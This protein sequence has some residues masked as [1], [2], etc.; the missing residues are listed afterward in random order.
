MKNS[1][2]LPKPYIEIADNISEEERSRIH[3]SV[4]E[5]TEDWWHQFPNVWI[6]SGQRATFWRDLAKAGLA[7]DSAG[8]ILVLR[9]PTTQRSWASTGKQMGAAWLHANYAGKPGDAE[10]SAPSRE[11]L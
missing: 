1:S 8:R 10:S 6:V 11:K 4:K 9:L 7:S 2:P 5:K 3:R